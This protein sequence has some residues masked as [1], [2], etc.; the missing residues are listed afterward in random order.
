[1]IGEKVLFDTN[2]LL[3]VM[4]RRKGHVEASTL[5]LDLAIAGH[6]HGY[7]A[8]HAVSTLIYILGLLSFLFVAPVN[9]QIIQKTLDSRFHDLEDGITH[10]AAISEG[11]STI[12]TRNVKD[13][14]ASEIKAVT[15][16]VLIPPVGRLCEMVEKGIF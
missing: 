16:T 9:G 15:P 14:A 2:V 5:A 4:L 7:V 12:V 8:A 3:D 11:V 13:F 6:V 10:Y 1:M